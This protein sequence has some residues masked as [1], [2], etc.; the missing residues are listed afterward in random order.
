MVETNQ[1]QAGAID[2]LSAAKA[3]QNET[4]EAKDVRACGQT[5]ANDVR[6]VLMTNQIY[7]M[8]AEALF[9]QISQQK[10]GTSLLTYTNYTTLHVGILQNNWFN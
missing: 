9:V 10:N 5:P 1:N 8:T 4:A 3:D 7:E 2:V 6:D